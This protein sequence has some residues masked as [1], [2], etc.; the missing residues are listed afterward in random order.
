M[1]ILFALRWQPKHVFFFCP[2]LAQF[3][4]RIYG[5]V[6]KAYVPR[7][8]RARMEEKL[9]PYVETIGQSQ[10]AAGPADAG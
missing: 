3:A 2:P 7:A 8:E 6:E 10:Q 4:Q 9:R 5:Y 1:H